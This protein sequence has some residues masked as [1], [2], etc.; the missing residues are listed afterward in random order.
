MHD[1]CSNAYALTFTL[2]LF[3][4]LD[5][6]EKFLARPPLGSCTKLLLVCLRGRVHPSQRS[7]KVP[8]VG[9]SP[10]W[11][12]RSSH[13]MS[14]WLGASCPCVSWE[15]LSLAQ[16]G[17]R[18]PWDDA[19]QCPSRITVPQSAPRHLP[20]SFDKFICFFY[21]C[22]QVESLVSLCNSLVNV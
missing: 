15:M 20:P 2:S 13:A 11:P 4:F 14:H 7:T 9:Q 18:M 8:A 1:W 10:M 19:Q 21:T 17:L 3:S 16:G 22:F 5:K 12:S 6:L